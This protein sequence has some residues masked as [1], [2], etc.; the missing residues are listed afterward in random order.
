MH[1][2]AFPETRAI[3]IQVLD[4]FI[5]MTLNCLFDKSVLITL[6]F[7]FYIVLLDLRF[8]FIC[9]GQ[10]SGLLFEASPETGSIGLKF[11]IVMYQLNIVFDELTYHRFVYR[12]FSSITVDNVQGI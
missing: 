2:P 8:L 3:K 10:I 6:N 11:G 4:K 5:E 7:F 9:S 1:F 12:V